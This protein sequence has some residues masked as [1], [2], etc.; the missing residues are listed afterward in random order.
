MVLDQTPGEENGAWNPVGSL[1][2]KI[3]VKR[4]A[5]LLAMEVVLKGVCVV[6]FGQGQGQSGVKVRVLNL[7]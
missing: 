5:L 7:A 4:K 1:E 6:R 3:P 2:T